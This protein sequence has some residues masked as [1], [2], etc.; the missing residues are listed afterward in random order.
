MSVTTG[1]DALIG[2]SLRRFFFPL[3][4]TAGAAAG[5]LVDAG[6]TQ[7]SIVVLALA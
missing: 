5:A 4:S 6:A 1:R 7:V 2:L 3:G